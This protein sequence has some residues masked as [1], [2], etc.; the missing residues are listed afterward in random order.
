MSSLPDRVGASIAMNRFGLGARPGEWVD[1]DPRAWLVRQF[2]DFQI[3]PSGFASLADAR[4]MVM[5]NLIE[6]RAARKLSGPQPMAG[7][8][9]SVPMAAPTRTPTRA[10]QFNLDARALYRSAV[11][12]RALSAINTDA[13]F[14]ERMVHFWA[15][16]FAISADNPNM[17]ALAGVFELEAIRPHVLGRFE[18]MLQA[19][20]RHPAMLI[21]LNQIRSIGP[22]SAA[23][24]R[25]A[26][27]NRTVGLNENLG[28]EIM[29]LHTL[30]VRSGY[31]QSDVTAF[32]RALTGWT[33][34][35]VG[36]GAKPE[37]PA[38]DFIFL[39]DYHEPGSRRIMGRDYP[40]AGEA[41]AS[42]VLRDLSREQATAHHVATKIARHFA[43]DD[44]PTALVQRLASVFRDSGGDLP[45]LYKCLIDSEEPWSPTV[46]KFKAPWEWTISVMRALG[47]RNLDGEKIAIVLSQ[48]GQDAWRPGSPAGWD[49][50]AP[51]WIGSNALMR[52]VEL[53]QKWAAGKGQEI[54]AV[55]LMKDVIPHAAYPGLSDELERAESRDTALALLFISPPFLRR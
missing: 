36:A 11:Q 28:R 42:A 20:E 7:D 49:D 15:N 9:K 31:D 19:V 33:V 46:S 17:T 45:A 29:E 55:A 14:I 47:I 2:D 35:G 26:R 23:A 40:P 21:Y 3:K 25:A 10:A 24:R 1:G 54:D 52:R 38:G 16:H 43:G 51:S 32:A 18:D 44:P 50:V 8:N 12:A 4:A 30:G 41:Q 13:P 48:L 5:A 34:N 53:A 6:Q 39:A 22:Q 37:R 27:R